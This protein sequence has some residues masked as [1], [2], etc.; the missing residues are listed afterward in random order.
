LNCEMEGERVAKV[1][2]L[3]DKSPPIIAAFCKFGLLLKE[4]GNTI[5]ERDQLKEELKRCQSSNEPKH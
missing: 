1:D 4:L 3:F 2:F 5:Y